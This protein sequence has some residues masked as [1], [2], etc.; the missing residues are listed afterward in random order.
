ENF[1]DTDL[2]I[3][4]F[5]VLSEFG[6]SREVARAVTK[7]LKNNDTPNPIILSVLV[8]SKSRLANK[9]IESFLLSQID[10]SRSV[11]QSK[12]WLPLARLWI[13]S[14]HKVLNDHIRNL[15]LSPK[16]KIEWDKLGIIQ[17][18]QKQTQT[19]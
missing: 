18:L 11:S 9:K 1:P 6:T 19:S 5:F 14:D 2:E 3:W 15:F 7:Y 16:G 10:D 12:W 8:K 4:F 17:Y 13:K